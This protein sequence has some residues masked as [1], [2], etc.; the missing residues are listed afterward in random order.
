[1]SEVQQSDYFWGT[2]DWLSE[3]QQSEYIWGT[4]FWQCLGYRSL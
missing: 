4:A 2:A 1:M 3:A